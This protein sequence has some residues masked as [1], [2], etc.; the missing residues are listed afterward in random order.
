ME[1]RITVNGLNSLIIS[2]NL[3]SG[4]G[5]GGTQIFTQ[6]NAIATNLTFM[7][8]SFDGFAI[9]ALN[10]N[11]TCDPMMDISSITI[12]G[13]NTVI[14]GPPTINPQPRGGYRR[15]PTVPAPFPWVPK[16]SM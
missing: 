1:L 16:A 8:S 3:Y 2:N 4:A 11:G 14:S 7:T 5:T 12:T 9:G 13:T 15:D 6:T 10:K